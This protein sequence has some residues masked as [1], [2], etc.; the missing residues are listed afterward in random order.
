MDQGDDQLNLLLVPFWETLDFIG[1]FS[2]YLSFSIQVG[3]FSLTS[4][5]LIPFKA[6]K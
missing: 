4:A 2:F 3:N 6:A 5:V 1:Q